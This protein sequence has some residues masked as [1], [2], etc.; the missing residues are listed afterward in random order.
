MDKILL[1]TYGLRH[2]FCVKLTKFYSIY[3][4]KGFFLNKNVLVLINQFIHTK[5]KK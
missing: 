3:L 4:L 5:K 1:T 2:I